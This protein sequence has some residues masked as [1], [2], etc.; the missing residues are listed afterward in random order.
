MCDVTLAIPFNDAG[1]D[2]ERPCQPPRQYSSPALMAPAPPRSNAQVILDALCS[3]HCQGPRLLCLFIT[4]ML[5]TLVSVAYCP[6]CLFLLFIVAS[7]TCFT[8]P[9]MRLVFLVTSFCILYTMPGVRTTLFDMGRSNM[10]TVQLQWPEGHPQVPHH[11]R[12]YD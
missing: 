10:P 8:V 5:Y 2:L 6:Q 7:M 9:G 3:T 4:C 12:G 1:T 11:G